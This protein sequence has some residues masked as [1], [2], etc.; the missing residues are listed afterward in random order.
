MTFPKHRI[1]Q[2]AVMI[3][4]GFVGMALYFVLA[5]LYADWQFLRMARLTAMQQQRQVQ[6]TAAP[7]P[8]ETSSTG[9]QEQPEAP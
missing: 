3:I 4:S 6:Q 1:I 7:R 5:G 2:A 8:P 9:P